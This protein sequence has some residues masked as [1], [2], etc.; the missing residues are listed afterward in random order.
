MERQGRRTRPEALYIIS[1]PLS[2][3]IGELW[4][5]IEAHREEM[6]NPPATLEELV[7]LWGTEWCIFTGLVNAQ[8]ACW[9]I[10][11]GPV[12][13]NGGWNSTGLT[14][15]VLPAFRGK[16]ALKLVR[17]FTTMGARWGFTEVWTGCRTAHAKRMARLCGFRPTHAEGGVTYYAMNPQ[18]EGYAC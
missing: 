2:P 17:I 5:E 14:L 11:T 1:R 6:V 9:F 16:H 12:M 4:R 7:A 15:V 3:S 18:E 10:L 13:R 8:E